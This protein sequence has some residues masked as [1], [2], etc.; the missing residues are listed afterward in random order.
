MRFDCSNEQYP[1][2]THLSC[3]RSSQCAQHV[4]DYLETVMRM[5]SFLMDC[6]IFAIDS[7]R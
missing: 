2:S 5:G 4:L 6:K 3:K 1:S 7:M